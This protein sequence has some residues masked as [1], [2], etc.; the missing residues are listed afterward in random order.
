MRTLLAAVLLTATTI[1]AAPV[2][3][4]T[5]TGGFRAPASA[6]GAGH[7][8]I[9]LLAGPGTPVLAPISGVITFA[10]RVGGKDVVTVSDGRRLVSLEPVV[11]RVDVG[12]PVAAGATIGTTGAGGHCSLRCVHVGLRIDGEYVPPLQ[13]HARLLP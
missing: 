11:A 3:P 1:D 6:Y 4:A 8:G 10:G 9:D 13:V 12:S 5:I 7:R 2:Q